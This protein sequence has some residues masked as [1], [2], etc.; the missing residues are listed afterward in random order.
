[1]LNFVQ[2]SIGVVFLV[3][4]ASSI[5]QFSDFRWNVTSVTAVL[6]L[7]VFGSAFAFVTLYHLL[8]TTSASRLSLIA[9][10]TPIVAA[11]LDWVVL[12]DTP[13]WA[14]GIGALLVLGGIYIVNILGERR[15]GRVVP[16]SAAEAV[17]CE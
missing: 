14:T 7:A 13:T 8:K 9:F 10:A 2:M 15:A 1:M 3:A 6:F 12:G 16:V 4:L 17:D 11:I 5:E